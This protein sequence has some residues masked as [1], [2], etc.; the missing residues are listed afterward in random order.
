MPFDRFNHP[1][2]QPLIVESHA[3]LHGKMQTKNYNVTVRIIVH[4][5]QRSPIPLYKKMWEFMNARPQ[6]F[7]RTYDEGIRRVRNSNGK[8]VLLI[9]SPKNDYING[10]QPCDTIKIGRNIDSKGFGVATPFGSPL[11]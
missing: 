7:V 1:N 2:F 5:A 3:T 9:E 4:H 8:Y 6:L 10:R 11:K